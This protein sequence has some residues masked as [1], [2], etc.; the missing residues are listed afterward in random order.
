MRPEK[1][2]LP[3]VKRQKRQVADHKISG[4]HGFIILRDGNVLKVGQ[5]VFF[6]ERQHGIQWH[7][8]THYNMHIAELT[9]IGCDLFGFFLAMGA[10]RVEQHQQHGFVGGQVL[11]G[12][13]G[14]SVR[15]QQ[16]D[17]G[18]T[19]KPL[20]WGLNAVFLGKGL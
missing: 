19:G 12:K 13:I 6:P 8:C 15:E 14:N 3:V 7:R 10:G 11:F 20:I 5:L 4:H 18:E 9:D 2:F 16:A 17:R 1:F